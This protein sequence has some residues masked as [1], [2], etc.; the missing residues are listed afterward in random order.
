MRTHDSAPAE[1][2]PAHSVG[3]FPC[4]A[5]DI[6]RYCITVRFLTAADAAF[7]EAPEEVTLP[8]VGPD[9]VEWRGSW[10]RLAR[11]V[12]CGMWPGS[13]QP[14][15]A[16]WLMHG[17]RYIDPVNEHDLPYLMTREKFLSDVAAGY[18]TDDDGYAIPVRDGYEMPCGLHGS[19]AA[20]PE[21]ATHVR[22]IN[23]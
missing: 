21:D 18:L 19:L 8:F 1:A 16:L 7:Y 13:L 12:G 9:L 10:Y 3:L 17:G 20:L 2:A 15:V 4:A 5:V 11:V 14:S 22:W 23:K 6:G